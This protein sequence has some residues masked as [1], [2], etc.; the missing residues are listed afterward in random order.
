M[1]FNEMMM[2]SALKLSWSFILLAHWKNTLQIDML[3][4]FGHITLIP[5]QPVFAL[6]SVMLWA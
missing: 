2:M 3:F 1:L 6:S 4:H 5:S